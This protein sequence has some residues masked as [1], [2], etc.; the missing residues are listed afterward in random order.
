MPD[1]ISGG[2]STG[3]RGAIC[4]LLM[5]ESSSPDAV[6]SAIGWTVSLL[7]GSLA[8]AIAMIAVA[9]VGFLALQGRLDL[10]RAVAVILGCFIIFGASGIASGIADMLGP[11][12]QDGSSGPPQPTPPPAV[13][14]QSSPTSQPYDPYAGAALPQR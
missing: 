4:S 2:G 6:G 12:G 9:G 10:R 14:A 3:S 11:A 13:A 7:S 5:N 1:A 8:V